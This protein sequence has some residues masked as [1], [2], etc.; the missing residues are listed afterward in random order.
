MQELP[1]PR[2]LMVFKD[3]YQA[4]AKQMWAADAHTQLQELL[5]QPNQVDLP[6]AIYED[7][8]GRERFLELLTAMALKV[9]ESL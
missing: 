6:P 8:I 3:A 7:C 5:K 4:G 9:A 2:T 1:P